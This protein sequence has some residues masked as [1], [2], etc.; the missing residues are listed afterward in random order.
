[1][2]CP[3]CSSEKIRVVDKRASDE[4]TIRR[5]R[6]C[7]SCKKRFTTYERV[8]TD[9]I[10]I[11]R[12]GRRERF[13]RNKLRTGIIK[14]CEKRPVSLRTIERLTKE[15]ESELRNL[16]TSEIKSST[17]GDLVLKKLRAV[18]KVAYVRFASY[19]K[20]FKNIGEFEKELKRLKKMK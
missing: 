7:L 9:L 11:K 13:D 10:V 17:I 16:S 1:M 2:R 4:R 12:D 19:Y 18:D 15:I 3:Y 8:E 6:E 5:R 14:A 20:H